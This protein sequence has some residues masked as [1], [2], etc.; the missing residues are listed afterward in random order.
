MFQ[1]HIQKNE[2]KIDRRPGLYHVYD[3]NYVFTLCTYTNLRVILSLTFSH[4]QLFN[5]VMH[6]VVF[7]YTTMWFQT[8]G[9]EKLIN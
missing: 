9:R 1:K 7:V 3:L 2:E 8:P 5:I 4:K 6:Y